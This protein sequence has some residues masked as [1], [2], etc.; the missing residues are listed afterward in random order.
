MLFLPS[1]DFPTLKIRNTDPIEV[2]RNILRNKLGQVFTFLVCSYTSLQVI[3]EIAAA[4][5]KTLMAVFY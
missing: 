2:S 3:P 1:K 5:F 4:I